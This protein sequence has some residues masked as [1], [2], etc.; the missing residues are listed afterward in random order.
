MS[1]L[2]YL[3]AVTIGAL[4]GVTELFP[5]SS[6]GHSVLVPAWIGGSWQ[7][8][9]TENASG[10]SGSS[11]YLAFIVALHVATALA[12]LAYFRKDWVAIVKALFTTLRTRTVTTS[13]ERLAWLLVVGTIPVGI[14]GLVLEHTFR[15]L[16]AKPE[17]AAIF[18][19]VNG[20]IL[21]TG[22]R[23][24]RGSVARTAALAPELSAGP[25]AATE[26]DIT[27]HASRRRLDDL[28]YREAGIIGLFQTLALL[29]G[30][31]RSGITMVGGLLRGLD[32]EDA[33]KFSFLLAT[34]VIFAAGLLKLPSLAGSAGDHIHGQVVV[35]FLTAGVCAYAAVRFLSRWFTTRTLTP[36]AI[37][38]LVAGVASM[39]WFA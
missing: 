4:Q 26:G 27:A 18:L 20:V 2:S 13:T 14:T 25:G 10:D 6:L 24:R 3:Q 38:C 36:F 39:I 5:V 16:F 22:E 31:S 35:G 33:A 19:T 28:N 9:V 1:D 37:Y 17:A 12:L 23:L 21:Y 11:P 32:H 15:T 34:P 8:L 30:I 7:H 29:A